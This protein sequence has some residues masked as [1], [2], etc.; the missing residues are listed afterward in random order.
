MTVAL[1]TKADQLPPRD[2]R[3]G[4]PTQ[5]MAE[6]LRVHILATAFDEFS[7][8]GVEGASMDSI[9]TKAKV[10]KRTLYAR[11]T[12]KTNLLTAA[13]L[14]GVDKHMKPISS[15]IPDGPVRERLLHVGGR[16]LDASLTPDVVRLENL[17]VWIADHEP[18]LRE[19][20]HEC[21]VR[22][23]MR[24]LQSILE[25]GASRGEI[26]LADPPFTAMFIFEA[27]VT[28]PRGQIL[29]GRWPRNTARDKR[30][31]LAKTLD[32]VLTG[33]SRSPDI[34]ESAGALQEQR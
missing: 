20:T 14:Y 9:A 29:S 23:P 10:S 33:L 13:I 17:L 15:N 1:R 16:M 7:H 12:S 24:I 26:V 8:H 21:A 19:M 2:P 3:G 22:V 25:D 32:L 31:W 28:M 11:F 4:R 34:A 27:L 6:R 5:E 18:Q 30:V